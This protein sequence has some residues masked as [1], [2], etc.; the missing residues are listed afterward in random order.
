MFNRSRSRVKF[1]EKI[2]IR[3]DFFQTSFNLI[4][5][6]F[7][8]TKEIFKGSIHFDQLTD[9]SFPW[10]RIHW[11]NPSFH[12]LRLT[13]DPFL[14][15]FVWFAM[16]IVRW[17][18]LISAQG[19]VHWWTSPLF[20]IE[21]QD[22]EDPRIDHEDLFLP[23][24]LNDVKLNEFRS[25]RFSRTNEH[26]SRFDPQPIETFV[27]PKQKKKKNVFFLNDQSKKGSISFLLPSR[28]I[29]KN[30]SCFDVFYI[31]RFQHGLFTSALFSMS[32][33]S[34]MIEVN[35]EIN[36]TFV[37]FQCWQNESIQRGVANG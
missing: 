34:I 7:F 29:A 6:D 14:K 8:M 36:S 21:N 5:K 17:D 18:S 24:L 11:K 9:R 13:F 2:R 31:R 26:L 35:S 3:F 4:E 1:V 19:E 32:T 22:E 37:R 23:R 30:R 12:R 20:L 27:N 10:R 16:L 33:M 15:R 25:R 28:S